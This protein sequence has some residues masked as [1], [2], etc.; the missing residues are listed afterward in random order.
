MVMAKGYDAQVMAQWVVPDARH[1]V[2]PLDVPPSFS[3]VI[4]VY[5]GAH[6]VGDAVESVLNQTVAPY[7]IIVCDDGSTDDVRGALAPFGDRVTLLEQAHKG[8]AAARNLA[9]SHAQGEFVVWCDSDD[10]L[11]PRCLEAL[12][13]F[14]MARPDLDILV[15]MSQIETDGKVQDFGSV[16]KMRNFP[17]NDLRMGILRHTIIPNVGTGVRRQRLADIGSF[18]ETLRCAEDYDVWIRLIFSGCRVGLLLEALWLW[19]PREGSLSTRTTW[20]FEGSIE[21][22]TKVVDRSDASDAERALARRR[23]ALFH[24]LLVL[25]EAKTALMEGRPDARRLCVQ[26][27]MGKGLG[28]RSRARAAVG[29]LSPKWAGRRMG[30]D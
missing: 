12:G 29:A 30:A 3:V 6:I 22:M 1:A 17:V 24:R 4:P 13:E 26:V 8:V 14:A 19:R 2:S 16:R 21:A 18:D 7:E 10:V 11:L 5:Q 15:P 27:V 28:L 25:G 23:I 20:C 9:L